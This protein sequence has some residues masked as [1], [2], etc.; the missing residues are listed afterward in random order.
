MRVFFLA[1]LVSLALVGCR[2][3]EPPAEPDRVTVSI[4]EGHEGFV[5]LVAYQDGA[6]A[7][8]ELDAVDGG[9]SFEVTD[10]AGRYGVALVCYYHGGT[11]VD[12]WR[13][14]E[15]VVFHATTDEFNDVTI[16]CIE[17]AWETPEATTD[18]TVTIEN[19]VPGAEHGIRVA[20]L[21]YW[22]R[23]APY[24]R[25]LG[26]LWEGLHDVVVYLED[27]SGAPERLVVHHDADTSAPGGV[28]VD[29]DQSLSTEVFD[30]TVEGVTAGA[31]VT[32]ISDLVTKNGTWKQLS[33]SGDLVD[34]TSYE[35]TYRA[36]PAA[37]LE[38]G[39]ENRLWVTAVDGSGSRRTVERSFLTGRDTEIQLPEGDLELTEVPVTQSGYPLY[40]LAWR[41]LDSAF[42]S[43]YFSFDTDDLGI[44]WEG[45]I[46]PGWSAG[47]A[48]TIPDLSGLEGWDAAWNASEADVV[49]AYF[50]ATA[51]FTAS[52]LSEEVLFLWDLPRE[53]ELRFLSQYLDPLDRR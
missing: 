32:V 28:S 21:T 40:G 52:E 51:V 14:L 41:D 45:T 39:H 23:E 13:Y 36:A 9:Y 50:S 8:R 17:A 4:A 38:A 48:Y 43:V 44:A 12:A 20:G 5:R 27:A 47:S 46:T 53:A 26:P 30:V 33:N 6:D 19:P 49:N 24:E 3:S 7:W 35:T 42:T 29:F 25:A 37:L 16:P 10:E 34:T 1:L 2:T 31:S 22:V 18:L 15:P 11:G